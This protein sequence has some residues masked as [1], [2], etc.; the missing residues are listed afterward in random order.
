MSNGNY[1][2]DATKRCVDSCEAYNAETHEESGEC[3]CFDKGWII[4]GDKC[5]QTC[6]CEPGF[7]PT[8]EG[9]THARNG[10]YKCV[11]SNT[12]LALT[13]TQKTTNKYL[14]CEVCAK[15]GEAK[16][17]LCPIIED[18][19]EAGYPFSRRSLMVYDDTLKGMRCVKD[20]PNKAKSF[21]KRFSKHVHICEQCDVSCS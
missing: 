14:Q 20:C 10:D 21:V 2:T 6:E 11:G 13:D 15:E 1:E 9:F 5:A 4:E 17:T 19:D 12:C 7:T 3:R 8:D 16:C 18:F